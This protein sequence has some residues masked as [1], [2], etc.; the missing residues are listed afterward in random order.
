I[1]NFAKPGFACRHNLNYWQQGDYL[2]FGPAAV[3]T[4]GDLRSTNIPDLRGY[5]Q[6][7]N[8]GQLPGRETE[9]LDDKTRCAERIMLSLRQNAGLDLESLR[10]DFGYDLL[11]A[12]R[13][14]LSD[15]VNSGDL[16]HDASNLR[17]TAKGMLRYNLIAAALMP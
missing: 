3:T 17:L 11:V 16:L 10:L 12:E 6:S 8:A 15:L 1:S 13:D 14:L 9:T 4:S 5:L 7:L 2:G